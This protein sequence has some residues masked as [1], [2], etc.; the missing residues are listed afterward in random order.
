MLRVRRRGRTS[1]G[2]DDQKASA[3]MSDAVDRLTAQ[4]AGT[5]PNVRP[6]DAATLIIIDRSGAN[7]TVLLGRRHD[8]HKF[9]PGK[10]VFPGG[11]VEALDRRMPAASE[12]DP[13]VEKQLEA[14]SGRSGA[15]KARAL[16]L[17][18]IRETFEE[19]GLMLGV[20]RGDAPEAPGG[21]WTA[22]A[23]AQVYPDL[24]A[25]HFVARAITPPGRPKRFDTRFFAVEADLIA[26]RID[27]IISPDAE[28]VELI[29]IPIAET[30]RLGLLTITT[31]VLE[32]LEARAAA[33]MRHDLAVPFYRMIKGQFVREML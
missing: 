23:Q 20:K 18:A 19:T 16:A 32:E 15:G 17:A 11:R 7:P 21:L 27:G 13:Y 1:A 29:W 10:F 33:G 9:M 4:G 31:V 5:L 8:A 3:S 6:Q 12:L 30:K 28:L 14:R 22:F 2:A 26:H 24:A 25:M